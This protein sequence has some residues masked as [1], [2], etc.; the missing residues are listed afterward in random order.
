MVQTK[1]VVLIIE[2]NE[3]FRKIYRDRIASDGYEVLEA[4]DG[5]EG[6][7]LLKK[8]GIDIVLC[9]IVMPKKDGRQ[10]IKEMS[11][12]PVMGKIPVII[13]SVLGEPDEIN[14]ALRDG[15][16][17]YLIKGRYTPNDVLSKI[18][19]LLAHINTKKHAQ[20]YI[21][22]IDEEKY[23]ALKLIQ[24]SGFKDLFTCKRCGMKRRLELIPQISQIGHF[25][26]RIFCDCD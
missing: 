11:E 5:Q 24:D 21:I 3:G 7:D 18:S 22:G 12:D 17:D 23:D 10:V 9:D 25:D 8:G 1:G 26:A 19:T 2:D 6:L 16:T 4:S 15:A 20:K 14:N 13:L